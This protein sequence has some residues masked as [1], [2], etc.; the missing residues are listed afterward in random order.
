MSKAAFI[1]G[2]WG[3]SKLRLYLCGEDGHVLAR[4]EG[5][6]VRDRGVE[7]HGVHVLEQEPDLAPEAAPEPQP[8]RQPA[9]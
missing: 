8:S 3:T 6:L 1:A 4:A 5:D 7:E 9:P 2:D